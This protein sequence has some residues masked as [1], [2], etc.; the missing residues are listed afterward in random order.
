MTTSQITAENE[1]GE[2]TTVTLTRTDLS[3][4]DDQQDSG[5]N[6]TINGHSESP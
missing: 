5:I 3:D 1:I 4:D 2:G 6:N